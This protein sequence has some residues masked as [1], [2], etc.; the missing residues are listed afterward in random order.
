MVK[1]L[2]STSS[3]PTTPSSLGT[4]TPPGASAGRS[5]MSSPRMTAL[6]PSCPSCSGPLEQDSWRPFI[7]LCPICGLLLTPPHGNA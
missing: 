4:G 2:E 6:G 5:P 3:T 7:W 1:S